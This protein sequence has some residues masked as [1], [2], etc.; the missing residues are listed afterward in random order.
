MPAL[1]V[2]SWWITCHRLG[3]VL[4]GAGTDVRCVGAGQVYLGSYRAHLQLP[5]NPVDSEVVLWGDT[6]PQGRLRNGT[7]VPCL[8]HAPAGRLV[9]VLRL[10]SM[11]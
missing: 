10:I 2:A 3:W 5:V 8:H 6:S 7:C 1:P 11:R 4:P 9:R